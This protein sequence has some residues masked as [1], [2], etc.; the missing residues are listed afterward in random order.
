MRTILEVNY[1]G[2]GLAAWSLLDFYEQIFL[3]LISFFRLFLQDLLKKWQL[4]STDNYSTVELDSGLLATSIDD[5]ITCIDLRYSSSSMPSCSIIAAKFGSS[6]RYFWYKLSSSF[7][8]MH[9]IPTETSLRRLAKRLFAMWLP[10][11]VLVFFG[12]QVLVITEYSE[13]SYL[14]PN[15]RRL[16]NSDKST[17]VHSLRY[18]YSPYSFKTNW[19]FQAVRELDQSSLEVDKK[20]WA[21]HK[22]LTA[23]WKRGFRR[24]NVE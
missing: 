5:W 23:K 1:V 2:K 19:L 24:T 9:L 8:S 20:F 18:C 7:G 21:L 11:P 4:V 10:N 15:Q 3:E 6:A 22:R 17:T 16:T 14:T 12:A 13:Y